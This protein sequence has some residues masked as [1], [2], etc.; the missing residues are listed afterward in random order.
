MAL[1]RKGRNVDNTTHEIDPN[2]VTKEEGQYYD[3]ESTGDKGGRKMSRIGGILGGESDQDSQLGV[4]KQ[5]ELEATNSIKY[6]TCSWKKVIRSIHHLVFLLQGTRVS[7][8]SCDEELR[9]MR[10]LLDMLSSYRVTEWTCIL[11]SGDRLLRCSS[12]SI[13]AWLSCRSLTPTPSWVWFLV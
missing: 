12:R 9:A 7:V 1:G 13:S 3:A 10:R 11:T 2:S 6:R 8:L 4:G 5:L